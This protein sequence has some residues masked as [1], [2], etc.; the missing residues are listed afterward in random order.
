MLVTGAVARFIGSPRSRVVV[1]AAVLAGC[2]SLTAGNHLKWLSSWVRQ[3]AAIEALSG[4]PELATR[5][6]LVICDT[7]VDRPGAN[8]WSWHGILLTVTNGASLKLVP[9]MT[10]DPQLAE[11]TV[12]ETPVP[13]LERSDFDL[14]TRYLGLKVLQPAALPRYLRSLITIRVSGALATPVRPAG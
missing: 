2:M 8:F 1:L 7:F 12:T 13:F 9:T 14:V 11:L 3:R 5:S 6:S 10:N 4:M